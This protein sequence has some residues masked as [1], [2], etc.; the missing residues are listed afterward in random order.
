LTAKVAG[1]PATPFVPRIAAQ[2]SDANTTWQLFRLALPLPT[3]LPS[4][5]QI[6]FDSLH[7]LVGLVELQAGKG[8]AWMIGARLAEGAN[9][10]EIDPATQALLPLE[11]DYQGGAFLTLSNQDSL[12]VVVM[13]V[14][15]PFR[16]FRVSAALAS[17]GSA[18]L[19]R[20]TGSTLCKDVVMY[21][22]F[23]QQLG[24][25]NT[26]TDLMSVVGAA[27]FAPFDGGPARAAAATA[28]TVTFAA[29]KS[30]V[31]ATLAGGS[32]RADQHV[33]AV[34]LVD[35]ATGRPVTLDYGPS[36]KRLTGR[37]QVITSVELPL[38]PGV[39]AN[40]RAYLMVDTYPA[41]MADLVIQ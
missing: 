34:L 18:P 7:Y 33:A 4:Y 5:N 24:L 6:G 3:L 14:G 17:D 26:V 2:P 28:G 29:D 27:N 35:A 11:V 37:N 13:N 39:P 30:R 16:S 19:A 21:G 9:T 15:I 22:P 20:V 8:V 10:T 25:C 40:V 12:E 41:A 31:V 38:K 32:L 23:L 1:P 36:T